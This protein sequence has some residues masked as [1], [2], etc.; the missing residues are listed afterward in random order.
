MTD[1]DTDWQTVRALADEAITRL[2]SDSPSI[3]ASAIWR[4]ADVLGALAA[5]TPT[6]IGA[7]R[8]TG[9][10]WRIV[11]TQERGDSCW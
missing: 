8:P 2:R 1:T 7:G 10:G 6:A 4:L 5:E 9:L 11:R 3:R